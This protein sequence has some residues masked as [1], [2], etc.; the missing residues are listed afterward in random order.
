MICIVPSVFKCIVHV[1]LDV[2]LLFSH[3]HRACMLPARKVRLLEADRVCTCIGLLYEGLHMSSCRS[4]KCIHAHRLHVLLELCLEAGR[5]RRQDRYRQ[6]HWLVLVLALALDLVLVL[7]SRMYPICTGG[8]FV[9]CC[10]SMDCIRSCAS[11]RSC[12]I[13][14]HVLERGMRR[15]A[16]PPFVALPP[17][18]PEPARS[19]IMEVIAQLHR[20][21]VVATGARTRW[22]RSRRRWTKW[23]RRY[24][25]IC[26]IGGPMQDLLSATRL[27]YH[28][29]PKCQDLG[30]A[31][32]RFVER[33]EHRPHGTI[34]QELMMTRQEL[35]CRT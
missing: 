30:P 28:H 14:P 35:C 1:P 31:L 19:A 15:I 9:R 3:F 4:R 5:M 2:D 27:Q 22:A 13:T 6:G 16:M 8:C 7:V 24:R 34:R 25:T 29:R 17:G 23:S 18:D 32:R 12:T 33:A 20:H 10:I 21:G 26:T 11:T